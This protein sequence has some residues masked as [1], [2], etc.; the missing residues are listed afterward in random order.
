MGQRYHHRHP[1][2]SG[3]PERPDQDHAGPLPGSGGKG[4][5]DPAQQVDAD[6]TVGGQEIELQSI[7]HF[8][9]ISEMIP[10]GGRSFGANLGGTFWSQYRMAESAAED[11]EG[12]CSMRKTM[13]R[14]IKAMG[15]VMGEDIP[16]KVEDQQLLD[17]IS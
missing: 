14:M 15:V 5:R 3:Q 11:G 7:H 9:I 8:Y 6:L 4:P 13:N 17:C 2:V 10:A 16:K 1:R 12:L